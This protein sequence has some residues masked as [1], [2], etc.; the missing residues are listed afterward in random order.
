VHR[1]TEAILA[2]SGVSYALARTSIFADYFVSA[3]R[4]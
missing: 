1:E 3:K 4:R 2:D